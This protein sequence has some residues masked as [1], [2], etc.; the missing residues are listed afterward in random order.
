MS[1]CTQDD[2]TFLY[3][4]FSSSFGQSGFVHVLAASSFA[5][6]MAFA[7]VFFQ[8]GNSFCRRCLMRHSRRS[9]SMWW[10]L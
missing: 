3:S 10:V 4:M 9:K 7:F 5:P 6:V 2:L 1:C 8:F